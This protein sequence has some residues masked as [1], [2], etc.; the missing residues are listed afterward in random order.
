V[1]RRRVARVAHHDSGDAGC[2]Q[3][4]VLKT[5]WLSVLDRVRLA[6]IAGQV[7]SHDKVV[8]FFLPAEASVPACVQRS[9]QTRSLSTTATTV[10]ASKYTH[11]VHAAYHGSVLLPS[12]LRHMCH[13]RCLAPP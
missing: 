13:G 11:T 7:P 6:M 12:L 2:I 1:S 5:L 10:Q 9:D 8:S 3:E 4:L